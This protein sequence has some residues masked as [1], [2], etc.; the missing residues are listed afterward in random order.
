MLHQAMSAGG[1][2][3]V[4]EESRDGLSLVLSGGSNEQTRSGERRVRKKEEEV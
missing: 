4:T 2:L 3:T 1:E